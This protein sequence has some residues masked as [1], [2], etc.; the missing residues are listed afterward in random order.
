MPING[1]SC[2]TAPN[3]QDLVIS[4]E[5]VMFILAEG[6]CMKSHMINHKIQKDFTCLPMNFEKD[7]KQFGVQTKLD[8]KIIQESF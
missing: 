2:H 8:L 5:N 3:G 1:Q 7:L 4:F 6:P